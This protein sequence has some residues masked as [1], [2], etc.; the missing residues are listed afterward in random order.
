MEKNCKW[1]FDKSGQAL[2]GPNDAIRETFKAN[3]YYS[4]V[5]ES[6]QNSLD[7][8]L[9]ENEPVKVVFFFDKIAKEDYPNLFDIKKHIIACWQTHKDD[10]QAE[11]LFQPMSSYIDGNTQIE[12]LKI[13]DYNTKGMNYNSSDYNS[14]F[15]SFVRAEGKSS[16]KDKGSGGSFGFGKGAYYVLSKLKTLIVSTMTDSRRTFFEGKTRLATHRIDDD[17]YTRDG[18]YNK[19]YANPVHKIEDIPDYFKRTESGTDIFIIGLIKLDDRK[20]QMIKSV[21]NNFWLAV[22]Y[23]KL[24]VQIDDVLIDKSSLEKIIEEYFPNEYESGSAT[25]IESWNPKP[26]FKAVKYSNANVNEQFKMFSSSLETLGEVKLFVYLEKGLPNRISYFRK[27]KMVVFKKTSRKVHGY[28]AVFLCENEKGNEIL[29]EMENPAHNEWKKGNYL[30]EN[31]EPHSDAKKAEKEI[32]DFINS[33]LDEL[34][35]VKTGKKLAFQGLEEYLSIPEDLLE[36]EEEFDFEGNLTNTVSGKV[37]KENTEDETGMQTTDKFENIKIRPTITPKQEIK[38]SDFVEQEDDGKEFGTT[39][40]NNENSG[41]DKP[42]GGDSEVDT[43]QPQEERTSRRKVLIKVGL[44][45]AA[46]TENGNVFHHLIVNSDNEIENAELEL[47]VGSD[48]DRDDSLEILTSDNGNVSN[49]TL[50]NVSLN[51]G[52]NLIKVRFADNLKHTVKIK[53]YEFQ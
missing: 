45:V 48:N 46:Q 25:D 4:I 53:A 20:T 44:K 9:D 43:V 19:D 16:K 26:Y 7:A 34:S 5:R 8:V 28:V 23:N 13:S 52:R 42:G 24:I 31:D 33:K 32:S 22:Q 40:G 6:I 38:E 27:P 51:S 18:F 36:S 11:K 10:K 21:L 29:K 15:T 17:V 1:H 37:S 3:P 12:I 30:N 2:T 50:K 14:G 41:G 39:G 47:L 49:N 35:K